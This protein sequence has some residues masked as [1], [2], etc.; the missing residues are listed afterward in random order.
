MK[1]RNSLFN[2]SLILAFLVIASF[3]L[4]GQA[5]RAPG[6]GGYAEEFLKTQWWLGIKIGTNFTDPNPETPY[7]SIS[8][9]GLPQQDL[10]KGY[11]VYSLP[12]AQAGLD[13]TFYH[14]GFAIGI[15]PTYKRIRY[16]YFNNRS[17][18]GPG[19]VNAF[20]MEYTIEQRIDAVDVPL[21]IKYEI[22]Q[23]GKTRPFV[24]LGGFYTFITHAEKKV[25]VLYTDYAAGEPIP[26]SGGT[27]IL[28]VTQQFQN[29][30]GALGGA[31]VS[32]DYFNIRSVLEVVYLM[33]LT[34]ITNDGNRFTQTELTSIGDVNDE[35]KVDNINISLSFVFPL[36]FI[37]KQFQAY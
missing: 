9:I 6:I 32:F 35:L 8:T 30:A 7:S 23:S 28:G 22:I 21:S 11:E 34:D 24:M 14:R 20:D 27:Q 12:G 15:Q 18:Q 31:G 17:W 33:G 4:L 29:Y 5:K 1:Q 16:K 13:I 37:D 3:S 2:R 25:D 36:R 10:E 26:T 19:L